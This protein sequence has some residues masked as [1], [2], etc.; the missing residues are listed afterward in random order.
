MKNNRVS[1]KLI[2]L[3]LVLTFILSGCNVLMDDSVSIDT[4]EKEDS[5]DTIKVG[6]SQLGS[7]SVWR[8]AHSVSI[9][10]T[11]T[12]EKGF[13]LE[14]NNARQKQENQIK[15][16]RGFIAEGVDY[17]VFS[18]VTEE[19]WDTVLSEACQA[20]IPVILADR[21]IS[22][23]NKNLY[24]AW[25]GSDAKAE[26]E[27]AARWLEDYLI[28]SNRS[29]EEINIVVLQ[30]TIGSSVELGRTMGFDVISDTHPNWHILIQ[31]SGDFTTAKGK[32]VMLE[33]LEKYED[34]DV[35]VSQN[36]DMTFGAIDAMN[37][38]GITY[39][40]N[41][42]V[43]VISFDAVTE[44]LRY[45]SEGKINVDIE[46]NPEEGA[47]IADII[48]RLENGEKVEKETVVDEMVFTKENVDKYIENRSY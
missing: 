41:G 23:A 3:V 28:S 44:A 43:I 17:I 12:K 46:C 37:E 36:D 40:E 20:G 1:K 13:S 2:W 11:L 18:P 4:E 26:G 48:K 24:T 27:K 32:E 9:Q 21:K 30:G 38:K 33:Y 29:M 42:D 31:S 7:E 8:I 14:F 25:I 22:T 47:Y 34:I 16:I 15:A 5:D 35:L 10:N 39:G 19:G 45:V 6:F